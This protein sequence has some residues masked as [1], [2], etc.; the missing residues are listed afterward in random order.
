LDARLKPIESAE[1][2]SA[3]RYRLLIQAS[4]E[5]PEIG[6]MNIVVHD[7]SATGFLIQCLEPLGSGAELSLELPGVQAVT[8]DIVWSSG[9]FYGGEFRTN[10]SMSALAQARSSSPVLWPDFVPKSAA[11]RGAVQTEA[12]IDVED[13][14]QA[15]EPS[16][17]RLPIGYRMLIIVGASILL[18]TPIALGIWSAVS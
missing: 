11:D 2:R 8:G 13:L 1:E 5:A 3:A 6:V 16:D 17:G 15:A 12:S 14:S 10:L 9:N 7:L 4:A 18:W